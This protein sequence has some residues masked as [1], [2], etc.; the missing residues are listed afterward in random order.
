MKK[1]RLKEIVFEHILLPSA[2]ILFFV[3]VVGSIC[4]LA[5]KSPRSDLPPRA[6][7]QPEAGQKVN[8][9]GIVG[10]VIRKCWFGGYR[11][12]VRTDDGDMVYM[13]DYEITGRTNYR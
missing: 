7:I 3:I 4:Y 1:E 11:Y 12:E 8:R 9:S 5:S 10:V 13:L 6:W 2:F